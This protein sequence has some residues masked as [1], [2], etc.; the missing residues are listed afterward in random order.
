[1]ANRDPLRE[2]RVTFL[3]KQTAPDGRLAGM[4][5]KYAQRWQL[6]AA[7]DKQAHRRRREIATSSVEA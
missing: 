6:A 2:Q 1:M 3:K 5:K 7:F 4:A